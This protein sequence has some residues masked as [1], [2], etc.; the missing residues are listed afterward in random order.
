VISL[1]LHHDRAIGD[2]LGFS[3]ATRLSFAN[4]GRR[5]IPAIGVVWHNR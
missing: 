1:R 3:G 2:S 4:R 5:M